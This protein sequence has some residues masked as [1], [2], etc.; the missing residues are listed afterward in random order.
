MRDLGEANKLFDKGQYS[1]SLKKYNDALTDD[2]DSSIINFGAGCAKY[3]EGNYPEAID[4]FNKGILSEDNYLAA[5]AYYNIGN[6]KYR[7]AENKKTISLEEAVAFYGE[8]LDYYKKAIEKNPQDKDAKY[9]YEFV[10]KKL[11]AA[12]KELEKQPKEKQKEKEPADQKREQEA[13]SK[14]EEKQKQQADEEDKGTEKEKQV[15]GRRQEEK[16][17]SEEEARM[18]IERFSQEEL[19]A[20]KKKQPVTYSQEYQDW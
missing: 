12:L 18:L 2:P 13:S 11:E 15:P 17:M 3:K 19:E 1:E 8:S 20:S 6:S 5:R 14:Q 10:A 7:L 4:N 16:P 9:N